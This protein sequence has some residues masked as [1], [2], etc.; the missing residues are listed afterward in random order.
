MSQQ[1]NAGENFTNTTPGNQV[2]YARLDNHVNG[3]ALTNGAVIDQVERTVP[4]AADTLLLGDSTQPDTAVPLKV[5]IQNLLLESQRNGSQRY[6]ATETGG[7][8]AYAVALTPAATAYA[9]GMEVNF[10]AGNANTGASTINVNGLGVK[11]IKNRA[12]ADLAANDILAGQI[13]H[14]TYDGTYFQTG[15]AATMIGAGGV[16]ENLRTAENQYAADT[17]AASAYACAPTP[18]I[19]AY[20]AGLV[21]RF[22]AAHTGAAGGTTLNVNGLG[23]KTIK[24]VVA[25]GFADLL[26][27]DIQANELVTCVYDGTYFQI[28]G[29]VRSWDFVSAN[30]AFPATGTPFVDIAHGLGVTPSKVRVVLV[31]TNASAANGY[32]QNQEL[33]LISALTGIGGTYGSAPLAQVS[34]NTTNVRISRNATALTYMLPYGGG[35]GVDVSAML[36]SGTQFMIKVYASI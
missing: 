31:Q 1:I 22:L 15:S 29:K 7:A 8:N 10:K 14:L 3:A 33:E 12:G 2:T 24:R 6:V 26:A 35:A 36:V 28:A 21:V 27:N 23:T 13:V 19:T 20:T 5:Q 18:A 16:T 17:G 30:T 9:A 32:P 11:T 34:Q 25:G 4:L